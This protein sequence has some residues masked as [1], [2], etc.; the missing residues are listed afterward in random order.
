[1]HH[2][3]VE[4]G[5]HQETFCGILLVPHNIVMDLKDVMHVFCAFHVK[6]Y[7][8]HYITTLQI[9]TLNQSMYHKY[10]KTHCTPLKG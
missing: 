7:V 2:I 1:M 10:D 3:Q 8:L 9:V 6:N 5:K 4:C